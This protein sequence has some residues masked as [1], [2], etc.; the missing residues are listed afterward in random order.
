MPDINSACTPVYSL[1]L[2]PASGF[3][4][5]IIFFKLLRFNLFISSNEA[6]NE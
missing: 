5:I 3:E 4:G 1:K 6:Y 2:N